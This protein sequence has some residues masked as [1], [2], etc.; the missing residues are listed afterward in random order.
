[1]AL[2]AVTV[3]E[4]FTPVLPFTGFAGLKQG[5]RMPCYRITDT[6]ATPYRAIVALVLGSI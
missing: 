4:L 6:L 1:L 2:F 5:S 3:R